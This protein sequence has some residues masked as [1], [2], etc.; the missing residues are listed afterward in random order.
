M[1]ISINDLKYFRFYTFRHHGETSPR[2]GLRPVTYHDSVRFP[3]RIMVFIDTGSDLLL[4]LTP[5]A[6]L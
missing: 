5:A 2:S 3:G 1:V 4:L 6:S